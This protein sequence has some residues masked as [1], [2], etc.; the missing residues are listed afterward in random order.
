VERAGD[1]IEHQKKEDGAKPPGVIHIEEVKK[2]QHIIE[3]DSV[4]LNIFPARRILFD[5]RA[6]NGEDGK[7]NEKK[8]REFEGTEKIEDDIK[9]PFFFMIHCNLLNFYGFK[10]IQANSPA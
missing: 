10:Y 6:D 8:D 1:Q 9:N 5:Q 2:L 4:S 3:L 7:Q